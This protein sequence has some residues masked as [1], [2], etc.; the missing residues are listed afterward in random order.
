MITISYAITVCNELNYIQNLIPHILKYKQPNDEIIVL[1]DETNGTEEVEEYLRS[2]SV[3]N[4]FRWYKEPFKNN[5]ADW[6]NKLNS[7]CNK[8]YIFNLDSDET[9]HEYMFE[10]IPNML[11][12]NKII[13]AV[14]L[15][16]INTLIGDEEDVKKY[17]NSQGWRMD[18]KGRINM[19]D[20]QLRI[21]RNTSKIHWQ[22]KVHE[23]IAGYNNYTKLPDNIEFCIIHEKTLDR[24]IK[25]N[26]LYSSI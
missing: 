17:V 15:S 11:S 16:R 6:K 24:Q 26:N 8:D 3:N 21:Y 19:P 9:I 14:W 25:Q 20:K 10:F 5:F 2:H 22:G 7:L 18:N 13:D 1:F 12:E 23:Q 4:E